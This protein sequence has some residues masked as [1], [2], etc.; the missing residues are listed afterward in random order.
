VSSAA[1]TAL[2]FAKHIGH[3]VGVMFIAR[4]NFFSRSIFTSF[5]SGVLSNFF[6]ASGFF[7]GNNR[8]M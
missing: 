6:A 2:T 4:M 3:G 7:F 5:S 1:S 8:S